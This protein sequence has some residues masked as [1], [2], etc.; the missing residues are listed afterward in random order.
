MDHAN[1]AALHEQCPAGCEAHIGLFLDFA[2]HTDRP[3]PD[4]YY[5]GEEGFEEVLD[6]VEATSRGLVEDIARRMGAQ[7]D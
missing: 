2:G 7:R 5:G 4:P 1:L 3:V 6:L